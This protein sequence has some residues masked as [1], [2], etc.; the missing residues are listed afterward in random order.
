[1][2]FGPATPNL[3]FSPPTPGCGDASIFF[4]FSFVLYIPVSFAPRF[5]NSCFT[6]KPVLALVS[7]NYISLSLFANSM[8]KLA[9]SSLVTCLF[10]S[11]SNL[12][13]TRTSII[14]TPL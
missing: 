3:N 2:F 13:P 4:P 11:S 9:P 7:M 1:V 12:L 8:A 14:S 6:F 5:L 10:S